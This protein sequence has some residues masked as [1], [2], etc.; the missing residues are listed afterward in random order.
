MIHYLIAHKQ[1]FTFDVYS[2]GLE[3]RQAMRDAIS[4]L[5]YPLDL[6]PDQ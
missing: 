3:N 1:E 6:Q 2:S 5:T 4:V